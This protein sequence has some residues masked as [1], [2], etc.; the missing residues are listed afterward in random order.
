MM[1]MVVFLYFMYIYIYICLCVCVCLCA[2]LY[3]KF[4]YQ[5]YNFLGAFVGCIAGW[6]T[7]LGTY[8]E[9]YA[10]DVQ[11]GNMIFYATLAGI[12]AGIYIYIYI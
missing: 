5:V 12:F 2:F 9:A 1:F 7:L 10:S 3:I 11:I 8:F 6:Q 4:I